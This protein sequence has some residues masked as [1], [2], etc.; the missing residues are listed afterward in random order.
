[1]CCGSDVSEKDIASVVASVAAPITL[2]AGM[3]K[4]F[5]RRA[6]DVRRIG[7]YGEATNDTPAIVPA[8]EALAL[9]S[10]EECGVPGYRVEW[11][12]GEKPA[13]ESAPVE[14]SGKRSRKGQD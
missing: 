13:Q 5:T 14:G 3:T 8:S 9:E 2:E 10:A 1:M 7:L 12:E 11:A 6:G 4:V